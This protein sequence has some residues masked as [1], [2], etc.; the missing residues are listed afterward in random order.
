MDKLLDYIDWDIEVRRHHMVDRE[1]PAVTVTEIEEGQIMQ[2]GGV[3]VSAFLV[4]HDPGEARVRLSLR[5]RRPQRGH[6]GR[7]PPLRQPDALEPDVDCLIHEC[8]EMAKTS[9]YPGCGWPTLEEKIRD[10]A[11]YHTQPDD[12]GR[13][14]AGARAR[15]LAVTHLMPGSE[16]A[17]LESRRPPSLRGPPRHRH[18]PPL[19]LG[20]LRHP[21]SGE[22][23]G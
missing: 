5:G 2:A 7:Y 18:R 16:P 23:A 10:L 22:R 21:S 12:L 3:T 14:A 1:P 20:T 9:W 11:S 8:C 4:E 13:V 17:E 6:L 15:K 19:G